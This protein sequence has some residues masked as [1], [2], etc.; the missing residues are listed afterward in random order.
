MGISIPYLVEVA[1]YLFSDASA[2]IAVVNTLLF[3]LSVVMLLFT[4][5]TDPGIIPRREI[6]EL[7]GEIP[8]KFRPP[9][10]ADLES[11]NSAAVNHAVGQNA[12]NQDMNYQN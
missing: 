5:F 3:T 1:P 2:F 12:F 8:K 9:S 10:K 11:Q 7:Y 4:S 6:L